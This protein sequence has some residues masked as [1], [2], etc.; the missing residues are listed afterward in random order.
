MKI[1]TT[2][3]FWY[4]LYNAFFHLTDAAR[5]IRFPI[6]LRSLSRIINIKNKMH[7]ILLLK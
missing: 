1:N 7:S 4:A 5:N 2:D 6:P 3:G